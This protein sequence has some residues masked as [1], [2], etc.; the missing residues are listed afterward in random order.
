ML[1]S[2]ATAPSRRQLINREKL[3]AL[4]AGDGIT[5]TLPYAE[6]LDPMLGGIDMLYLRV[7]SVQ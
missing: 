7:Q 3:H 1:F 5:I 6:P 2:N 4:N